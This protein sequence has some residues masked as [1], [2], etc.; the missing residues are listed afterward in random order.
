MSTRYSSQR[1]R[2][3]CRGCPCPERIHGKPRGTRMWRSTRAGR[4]KSARRDGPGRMPRHEARPPLY[5]F[6]SDS[7]QSM[8]LVDAF[9][10]HTGSTRSRVAGKSTA[11]W[12]ASRCASASI[13][14][15]RLPQWVCLGYDCSA[16]AEASFAPSVSDLTYRRYVKTRSRSLP[17]VSKRMSAFWRTSI[18]RRAVGALVC[19]SF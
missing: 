17:V 15:F 12:S 9:A 14:L 6:L 5:G 3:P 10:R 7:T 18:E 16:V 19:N 2:L 1:G 8:T 13:M 4:C 11:I